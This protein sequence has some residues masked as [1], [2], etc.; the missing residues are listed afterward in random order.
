MEITK[1]TLILFYFTFFFSLRSLFTSL[2]CESG[3]STK[4][5]SLLITQIGKQKFQMTN[6]Q[7][8]VIIA[9]LK[10]KE[11]YGTLKASKK[12]FAQ[13]DIFIALSDCTCSASTDPSS[14]TFED[15]V[16]STSS[17]D[18]RVANCLS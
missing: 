9:V 2:S 8:N 5:I 4:K 16:E 1:T 11:T 3:S 17:K 10:M 14:M 18:L 7:G 6:E 12:T 15:S 13:L